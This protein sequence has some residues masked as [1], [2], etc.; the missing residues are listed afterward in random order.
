MPHPTKPLHAITEI[1]VD[2]SAIVDLLPGNELGGAVGRRL[3][4]H[5]L[6]APAHLDAEVSALWADCTA[7]ATSRPKTSS[8][9]CKGW[10]LHRSSGTVSAICLSTPGPDVISYGSSMTCTSSWRSRLAFG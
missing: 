5:A 3:A 7:Q 8:R 1:V 9:R 10:P 2:A 6:Y 4:G